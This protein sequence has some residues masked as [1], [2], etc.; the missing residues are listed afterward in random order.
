MLSLAEPYG[1]I[2]AREKK[3]GYCDAAVFG[4]FSLWLAQKA[5]SA[6]ELATI[7]GKLMA[8]ATAYGEA[9]LAEREKIWSEMVAL[10]Q[11]VDLPEPSAPSLPEKPP[12]A[13][14][15]TLATTTSLQYLKGVGP[16]RAIQLGRLGL[17][18]IADI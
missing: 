11:M 5:V 8:L 16:K 18:N 7:Q 1:K 12:V 10:L 17:Q 2:F 9:S 4:G 3:S 6:P 13:K 14:K 15:S